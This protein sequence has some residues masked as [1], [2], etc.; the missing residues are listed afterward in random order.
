MTHNFTQYAKYA[1][2]QVLVILDDEFM[3]QCLGLYSQSFKKHSHITHN[4]NM[5]H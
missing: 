3:R 4:A 1:T 2:F 5:V